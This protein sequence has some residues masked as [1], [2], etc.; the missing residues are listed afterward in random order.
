MLLIRELLK[1]YFIL[2]SILF[3]GRVGL[4]FLFF[5][6]FAEIN[7]AESLLSFVYGLSMDSMLLGIIIAPIMLLGTLSPKKFENFVSKFL[8]FY[9]LFF[10]L[11]LLFSTTHY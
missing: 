4:Y 10:L 7:F 1:S 8:R 11:L 9:L 5:E 3:L 6:R 2:L